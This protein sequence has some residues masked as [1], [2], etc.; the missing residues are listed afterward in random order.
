MTP[1]KKRAPKR[2]NAARRDRRPARRSTRAASAE[3]SV[4]ELAGTVALGGADLLTIDDPLEAEQWASAMLGT[5]YKLPISFEARDEL[6]RE[7]GPAIVRLAEARADRGGLAVL[8][9]I[10]SVADAPLATAARAAADRMASAGVPRPTWASEL[11]AAEFERAWVL[12]D[13]FGDHEAYAA[14]FRYPGRRPHMLNALYDKAMGE[15]IKDA[16]VG[17]VRDDPQATLETASRREPGMTLADADPAAMARRVVDAIESG[18]LYLDNDWTPKFKQ[19]RALLLARMR[20]LPLGPEAERPELGDDARAEIIDAFLAAPGAPQGETAEIIADTCLG[21]SC[22]YLGDDPY[23][24]SPIVVE[25]FLLDFVPRKVSL[26]LGEIRE[27]P[28]VLRAWVRFAL[29]RRG[30]EERWIRETE[31]VVDEF[32]PAFLR[33]A[34]DPANFGPA[35]SIEAAMRADGVDFSDQASIDAWIREFNTRPLSERDA[36]RGPT[37]PPDA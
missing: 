31:E 33:E 5:F 14:V 16:G 1:M 30:L 9:A 22:D 15:I 18:D 10:A 27:L 2:R 8:E 12:T 29:T 3:P 35:K 20:S 25:Q 32:A 26:D 19:T 37:L 36:L 7:L 28:A 13:V 17:Y 34:T 6:E 23:R 24:W 21:Y 4:E 11:G